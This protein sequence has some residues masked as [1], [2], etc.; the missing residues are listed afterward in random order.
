[1]SYCDD[2]DEA[3][4]FFELEVDD[5]IS[6]KAP[7]KAAPRI[8][9]SRS[10]FAMPQFS[11]R[12]LVTSS[13]LFKSSEA[14]NCYDK[15]NN[16]RSTLS[17]NTAEKPKL[18]PSSAEKLMRYSVDSAVSFIENFSSLIPRDLPSFSTI[19]EGADESVEDP[20][21]EDCDLSEA[22]I[23]EFRC[24]GNVDR[25]MK[26][27]PTDSEFEF[28][29]GSTN[30]KYMNDNDGLAP[31]I[32]TASNNISIDSKHSVLHENDNNYD[33]NSTFED[34]LSKS[35]SCESFNT[36]TENVTVTVEKQNNTVNVRSV[37]SE[38]EE[39][40]VPIGGQVEVEVVPTVTQDKDDNKPVDSHIAAPVLSRRMSMMKVIGD[41]RNAREEKKE[42][43][44]GV[45]KESKIH[46]TADN[47]TKK[48]VVEVKNI[49]V[50]SAAAHV[51]SDIITVDKKDKESDK[52]QINKNDTTIIKFEIKK[53]LVSGDST[54]ST[55][56]TDNQILNIKIEGSQE[57]E[58][59]DV[60]ENV[61]VEITEV[62]VEVEA[63]VVIK[64]EEM[65]VSLET[66][67]PVTSKICHDIKQISNDKLNAEIPS[68][69]MSATESTDLVVLPSKAVTVKGALPLP[70]TAQVEKEVE[71]KVENE[72]EDAEGKVNKKHNSS[73]YSDINKFPFVLF[74][75]ALNLV[76]L[77][78][79]FAF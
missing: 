42:V 31:L 53:V 48:E 18:P 54:T 70:S 79:F 56:T 46:S 28:R 71:D 26:G 52:M 22:E 47:E 7:Q 2:D 8:E 49:T 35:Q 72:V 75:A 20:N 77:I 17:C 58:K 68:N 74:C 50:V 16:P 44:E 14:D 61:E 43:E 55:S 12:N 3:P 57:E 40:L 34:T 45:K 64:F 63:E 33:I 73:N 39:N 66:K 62:D 19:A 67:E 78:E 65:K 21:A 60:E 25:M 32:D 11:M 9:T 37:C 29:L 1:M 27:K 38:N 6:F 23:S 59:N 15:E 5:E 24:A 41:R 76:F 30:V 51:V 10:S 13:E 69:D 4:F 36:A